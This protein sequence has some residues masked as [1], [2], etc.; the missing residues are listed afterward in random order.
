M[1]RLRIFSSIDILLSLKC[2]GVF[3][4]NMGFPVITR[5]GISQFWYKHWCSKSNFFLNT[6]QDKLIFKLFKI[7]INY[8]VTFP[9]S[10]FFHEYFFTRKG[11]SLRNKIIFKN[12][13]YFRKI[14]FSCDSLE[15]EHTYFSRKKT[16]EFFPLR[17]WLFRYSD[18][19]ILAFSC[20]KPFKS[21]SLKNKSTI[22]KETHAVSPL[23]RYIPNKNRTDR[24]SVV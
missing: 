3:L 21:K 5:L 4:G 9:T 20:F 12:W 24:K 18:W 10:I 15:I 23:L 1:C 6:K 8:G 17:L 22:K 19:I 16:G 2:N 7:Y 13:K 14:F 11:K